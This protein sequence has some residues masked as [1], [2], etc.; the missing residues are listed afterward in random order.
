MGVKQ[1]LLLIFGNK[2]LLWMIM[3]RVR[4]LLLLWN[5]VFLA[6]EKLFLLDVLYQYLYKLH[7]G[8]RCF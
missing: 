3:V 8:S 4:V 5:R 2:Y 1:Q 6:C 7:G